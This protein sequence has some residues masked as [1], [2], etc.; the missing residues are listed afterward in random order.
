MIYLVI[1]ILAALASACFFKLGD[2][3]FFLSSMIFYIIPL[4]GST[5]A[6]RGG[7]N[8]GL[9]TIDCSAKNKPS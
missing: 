2:Q 3:V 9:G 4:D 5:A 8:Y 7:G 6:G 1:P